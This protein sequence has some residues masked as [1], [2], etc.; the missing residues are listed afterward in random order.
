M[1]YSLRD[2][3]SDK[4]GPFLGVSDDGRAAR[5]IVDMAL[6]SPKGAALPEPN[7]LTTGVAHDAERLQSIGE[8]PVGPE[9]FEQIHAISGGHVLITT[10]VGSHVNTWHY[11]EP[12]G[13]DVP[14]GATTEDVAAWAHT[15]GAGFSDRHPQPW[16]RLR[17][18]HDASYDL[19]VELTRAAAA[20]APVCVA[21]AADSGLMESMGALNIAAAAG[22]RGVVVD[23]TAVPPTEGR[24]ALPGLL[25]YFEVGAARQV[26]AAAHDRGVSVGPAL[27]VDTHA[28]ACQVWAALRTAQAMGSHLG[29]YGLFP[30]TFDEIADVVQRVQSWTRDWTA[31]PAFYVDVPWVDAAHVFDVVDAFAA[32]SRWLELVAAQGAQ[33]VL[34]DTVDKPQRR[35]LIRADADDA[36]GVLTWP[37][38]DAL[39]QTATNVGIRV[40]WAGG[41]QMTDLRKFGERRV[42]GVYVTSAVARERPVPAEDQRDIGL[43]TVKE[44]VRERISVA[45]LLLEAGFFED[46]SL[47]AFASRAE[48][49]DTEAGARLA[50]ALLVLWKGRLGIA[51]QDHP[52]PAMDAG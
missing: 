8:I 14:E 9:E 26:L 39:Q 20:E 24:S 11:R 16:L 45:K 7:P 23:G 30:L 21:V 1:T 51:P 52:N 32:A 44:P 28:V 2:Y 3:D 33:V 36:G 42:F 4:F 25:N 46:H 17:F 40:L 35:R 50:E 37:E 18:A 48:A 10:N 38:L 15:E 41:I 47:G 5:A 34:I 29:K 6:A 49:G 13:L 27:K 12:P 19:R 22:A 31:A 43:L